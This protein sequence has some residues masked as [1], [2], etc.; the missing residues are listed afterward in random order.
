MYNDLL[1]ADFNS[2]VQILAVHNLLTLSYNFYS[3]IN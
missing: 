1:I 2:Y 3:L